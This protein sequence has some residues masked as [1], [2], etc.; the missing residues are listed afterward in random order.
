MLMRN[1]GRSTIAMIILLTWACAGDEHCL[2][3]TTAARPKVQRVETAE[4]PDGRRSTGRIAVDPAG[5]VG[6][7]A[8]R[9]T[10]FV[11][12]ERLG[13]VVFDGPGPDASTASP[14]FLV[15]L[16]LGERLSGRLVSLNSEVVVLD[17]GLGRPVRTILRS[18]C[19]AISQ[20]P[21]EVQVLREGFETLDPNVWSQTGAPEL[22]STRKLVASRA[23]KLPS[24]SASITSALK[25]PLGAGRLDLAYW[26]DGERAPGQRWFLDM[27][28]RKGKS[29]EST[30]RIVPGWAEE[31]L[32]VETPAG[33]PLT[34]QPLSRK[35]GW[36]RLAVQFDEERT[37][38]SLDDDDLAHGPGLTG[39]LTKVRLASETSGGGKPAEGLA[40]I[41]DDL[42]IVRLVEPTGPF[43]V[44]PARDE[45][46]LVSG[47]QLFGKLLAANAEGVRL[48]LDGRE[49]DLSWAKV[50]ALYPRR[51]ASPST[52][53]EG[54][55]VE[56]EWRTA[57]GN[58]PRDLD[59]VEGVLVGAD[60]DDL[61]L[62]VPHVGSI[63][64]ARD[65]LKRL[66]IQR[67][68]SRILLDSN[69]H[70]L[71]DRIASDF[72]PPQPETAPL[73]IAFDLATIPPGAACVLVDAVKVIAEEGGGEYSELV[74]KGQ[75]RTTVWLNGRKIDDLNGHV[76]AFNENRQRLRLEVPAGVLKPG[77]NELRFDQAGTLAD[78][79][80][81]DNL[82]ILRI[83]LEFVNGEREQP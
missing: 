37:A 63:R 1:A 30:L 80:L 57:A 21:G 55:W 35:A 10:S 15:H 43:E 13:Q 22:T 48:D 67:R 41:V 72:D 19:S 49:M 83:S 29:D 62:K 11:P 18:R 28:F 3:Q 24:G 52:A 51:L 39:P 61:M 76:A 81:R 38:V 56:A 70:H 54:V 17:P 2:A 66:T 25:E 82:G 4:W 50:A 44:E 75:L 20:R 5:R 65:T 34:V 6:F 45:V 32:S 31:V 9:S 53:I 73:V 33:P 40:A 58:D 77:K 71:G 47:D 59:R 68:S 16:G 78:P 27:T 12:L 64:V 42:R 36:H 23:L 60:D 46:R 69:A 8:V 79:K 26:D 7:I 74:K 14:P